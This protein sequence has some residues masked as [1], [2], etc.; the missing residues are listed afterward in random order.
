M[1]LGALV[2][3]SRCILDFSASEGAFVIGPS[4]ISSFF[5]LYQYFSELLK[6]VKSFI[7]ELVILHI[8]DIIS[9]L[10]MITLL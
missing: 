10:L 9:F 2:V 6:L 7:S 3:L 8:F 5:L 4:Q 1:P